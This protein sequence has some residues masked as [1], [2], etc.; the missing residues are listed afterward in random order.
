MNITDEKELALLEKIS[1]EFTRKALLPDRMENDE[2]PYGKFWIEPLEKA[3]ELGFFHTLLPETLQ[4]SGRRI[5]PFCTVLQSLCETDAAMGTILF[6]NAFAQELL[7]IAGEDEALA[8]IIETGDG[9]ISFVTGFQAFANPSETGTRLKAVKT[10]QGYRLSGTAEY[11]VLGGLARRCLVTA[12]LNGGPS[13][14]Y[15]MVNLESSPVRRSDP[16]LSLGL[17]ACPAADMT[18][19]GVEGRLV[20]HADEGG[21]YFS[22]VCERLFPAMAAMSLGI[23][24]G[25]FKAAIDYSRKRVQGGKKIIDWTEVQM[26]LANMAYRLKTAEVMVEQAFRTADEKTPG[27]EQTGEA[28][29]LYLQELASEFTSDGIQILGGYGYIKEYGQEKYFRDAKQLQALAGIF[30]MKKIHYL[31]RYFHISP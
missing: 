23:M 20:G 7:L 3:F 9:A 27:W 18:F 10:N 19:E 29:A 26:M 8:S 4:G 2:Y 6:T 22:K 16:I 24:K 30:P 25:S 5:A 28:A 11:V 13:C 14:S 12:N 31:R 21:F 17:H 1:R 15:F